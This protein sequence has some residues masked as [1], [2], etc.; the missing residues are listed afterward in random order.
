MRPQ[1]GVINDAPTGTVMDRMDVKSDRPDAGTGATKTVSR[2]DV[3]LDS[4]GRLLRRGA[5][6]NLDRMVAKM[7]PA[8]IAKV[9]HHLNTVQEKRTVF[10][11]IKP[12]S[13]KGLALSE[14]EEGHISVMLADVPP[15]EIA[16]LI[17]DL[18]DDDQAYVLT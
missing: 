9:L 6:G 16:L 8:D 15:A 11:L 4:V 14:M 2:F 10:D 5:I 3:I 7:H 13:H 12:D 18:P 17:R 1:T